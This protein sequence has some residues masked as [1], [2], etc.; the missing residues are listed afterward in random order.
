M[1]KNVKQFLIFTL[2]VL[3]FS[4][5]KEKHP[6]E[7]KMLDELLLLVDSTEEALNYDL[8]TLNNRAA[9]IKFQIETFKRFNTETYTLE[10]GLRLDKYKEIY[11]V[12]KKFIDGFEPCYNTM[13][14]SEKQIEN[15]R[16]SVEDNKLT[17]EEFKKF[18]QDE[19]SRALV[20]L[21]KARK[22]SKFIPAM[23]PEFQRLHKEVDAMLNHV[24]KSDSTL[25]RIL[26]EELGGKD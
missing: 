1:R 21:A 22:I 5:C 10:T 15:L 11:K 26:D 7:M 24:A 23:E 17:K 16:N 8:I 9:L 18:H 3:I 4:S 14:L 19:K 25:R 6:H 20:N 13:K 2:S 12:Y